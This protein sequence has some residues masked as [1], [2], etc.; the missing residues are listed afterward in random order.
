M[1][2]SLIPSLMAGNNI[3][4]YERGSKLHQVKATT[5]SIHPPFNNKN[6]NSV[7]TNGKNANELKGQHIINSKIFHDFL[8]KI[9]ENV[10]SL[11]SIG[12]RVLFR[13]YCI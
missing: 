9:I 8:L 11:Y 1:S 3:K 6:Q 2:S 4:N 10:S 12:M 13:L 7:C 5:N